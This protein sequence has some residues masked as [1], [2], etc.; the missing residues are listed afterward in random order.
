LNLIR[1]M[2][3]KGQDTSMANSVFIARRPMLFAVGVPLCFFGYL[4]SEPA[5][6]GSLS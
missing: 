6:I 2:P 1:V 4:R 3:A 5:R